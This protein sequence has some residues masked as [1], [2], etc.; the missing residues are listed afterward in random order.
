MTAPIEYQEPQ[1]PGALQSYLLALKA[2]TRPLKCPEIPARY[3]SLVENIERAFSKCNG[4]PA[5]M[6]RTFDSL[7]KSDERLAEL[8][9]PPVPL[10]RVE[11]RDEKTVPPLPGCATES[12]E[13]LLPKVSP[14]LAEYIQYSKYV[15]PEGYKDYHM[16]CGLWALSTVAAR[17]IQVP[18]ADPVF[19]PLTV[20]MVG[21]TSLFAKSTTAKA[22]IRLLNAAD[23]GWM[24]G[25]DETTPQRLLADM[26][27][28]IPT[29]YADLN[30]DQKQLA[31]QKIAMS[32][33]IGWYYD[34]FNQL[35][36]AMK[37]PGPMADFAGLLR[38]L[39]NCVDEY[40]YST[41][42]GGRMVIK[43]PYVA[44]AASTTP[45]NLAKHASVGGEFWRD[46]FW[47]RM[48]FVCPD[49]HD[50]QTSTMKLGIVHPPA[51]L[52][53]YLSHWNQ[54][55][56]IPKTIIE[57][58]RNDEGEPTGRYVA[59]EVVPLPLH[60]IRMDREVHDAFDRYRIDLRT[61]VAENNIEDLDGSY[62]RLA[63]AAMRIAALI[64]SLEN[65]NHLQI[66][67]WQLAQALAEM[68]RAN[69]HEL[70]SQVNVTQNESPLQEMIISYMKSL[71][72]SPTTARE[73]QR[74]GK[75]E[76][77][78]IKSITLRDILI[79]L[80]RNNVLEKVLVQ[81]SKA[82]WFKLKENH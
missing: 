75:A 10:A 36:D 58:I 7:S 73:I 32:G 49:P 41:R 64:A 33:Q 39:D 11:V 30:D 28:H 20:V 66:P 71:E 70:Y 3:L 48:L 77:R 12:L 15:S 22:A 27:G 23:L 61:L 46:G 51:N 6:E 25:D 19:T 5:G 45:A 62:T 81:G 60:D 24:L 59:Q 43:N 13:H 76:L 1:D 72:G 14:W 56:G 37:R 44:L 65:R 38:K 26:A 35:I 17:R 34:E 21:R 50:F 82:E 55:L 69:L 74:N 57:E 52:V 18:L 2:G 31:E 47:S 8:L 54:R 29:N 42:S 40:K 67:Q 4:S 78:K 53:A 63:T 16:A 80:I 68:F 9:N 79:D